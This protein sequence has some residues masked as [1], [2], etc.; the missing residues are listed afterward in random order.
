MRD[1]TEKKTTKR[2]CYTKAKLY[3]RR[4]SC[5]SAREIHDDNILYQY[6]N[7][8]EPTGLFFT[9]HLYGAFGRV[10]VAVSAV[11]DIGLFRMN[12]KF[13]FT[14]STTRITRDEITA[15]VLPRNYCFFRAVRGKPS[16]YTTGG[17]AARFDRSLCSRRYTALWP[18]VGVGFKV[19]EV[20][21]PRGL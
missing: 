3:R 7:T 11:C 20:P 19:V 8:A 14:L 1:G 9:R 6:N 15:S 21:E 4:Q 12:Y 18:R 10:G 2:A 16:T 17:N 13:H 5:I